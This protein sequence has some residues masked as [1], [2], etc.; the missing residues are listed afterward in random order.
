[1]H[2]AFPFFESE[3]QTIGEALATTHRSMLISANPYIFNGLQKGFDLTNDLRT[4]EFMIF[5]DA[6]NPAEFMKNQE[7]SSKLKRY[8]SYLSSSPYP[9][10]S[11]VNGLQYRRV[12]KQ[13]RSSI[14]ESSARDE[15]K[16]QYAAE[17]NAR[18][19]EFRAESE[20]DTFV[21]AN[22]MDIHP[23]LDA[24]QEAL[25]R[26]CGDIS[27]EEIPI[28]IRGQDVYER[29]RD[30]DE[31]I[32]DNMA[33]LFRAAVWDTDRKVA[34]LV[35]TLLEEDTFVVVTADHGTWFQ[36]ETE[37][38]EER[39][40]VPLLIFPPDGSA[41]QID[42]TVSIQSLPRTTLGGVD[43]PAVDEF[44]G[45]D[46]LTVAADTVSVTEFIHTEN[47]SG[48]PVNPTGDQREDEAFDMAAVCGENRID[49]IDESYVVR[50]GESHEELRDEIENR[51]ANL[52]ESSRREIQYDDE[53]KQRLKDF[54]YL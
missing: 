14:P 31:E 4:E 19:R 11:I 8:L 24:S 18:I 53:V 43:H 3:I 29:V 46:L 15:N 27:P 25:D 21:V 39:I 10:R 38:D 2:E 47:D 54:G 32:G 12:Q 16:F 7:Y 42:H 28:G 48:A 50:R 20:E 51:V 34:P 22:Y 44:P 36:R 23:P 26:F 41:R 13:R 49:Y 30:G 17:M 9:L 37:L 33:A 40:H 52:T 5:P 45:D 1:M 6:G 35:E